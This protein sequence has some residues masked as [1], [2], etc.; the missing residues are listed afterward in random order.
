M[1]GLVAPPFTLA[2]EPGAAVALIE[3]P[4]L[5]NL[6]PS[7]TQQMITARMPSPLEHMH[8]ICVQAVERTVLIIA[9]VRLAGKHA[10][11]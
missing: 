7:F 2:G 4:P 1:S 3:H 5:F 6:P 8:R 10:I 11:D 9:G